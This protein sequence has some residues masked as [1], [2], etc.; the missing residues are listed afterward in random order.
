GAGFATRTLYENREEELFDAARPIILNGIDDLATRD[1]LR[2]RS[3]ILTLPPIPDHM[4][5]EEADIWSAFEEAR[6][7]ILG[8]LLDAVSMALRRWD[9]VRLTER[10]RMA[11]FARLVAAAEPALGWPEGSFLDA[12]TENRQEAVSVFLEANPIA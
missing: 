5:R 11:D 6:P 8:A 2:D 1:D 12:Y 3:L 9:E 4:R 10:P 7:R